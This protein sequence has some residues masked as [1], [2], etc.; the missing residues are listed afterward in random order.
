ML[1]CR[2][3]FHVLPEPVNVLFGTSTNRHSAN[4]ELT[5][6]DLSRTPRL[7]VQQ[8]EASWKQNSVFTQDSSEE[9]VFRATA[10]LRLYLALSG[11][12]SFNHSMLSF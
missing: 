1:L 6:N 8:G 7:C 12:C 9:P 5:G 10:E 4:T 3:L 11:C 2:L